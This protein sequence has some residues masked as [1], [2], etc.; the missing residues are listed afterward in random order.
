[1][2]N[3][4]RVAL[5]LLAVAAAGF[6]VARCV[7][8]SIPRLSEV[9]VRESV[10]ATLQRE[11]DTAFVVTGYVDMVVTARST[12]TRVLL[13]DLLDLRLGTTRATVRVPGRVSYGFDVSELRPESIRLAGDTVELR[14]PAPV[15]YSAEPDLSRMEVET[16]TGWA[17]LPETARD[18]ERRAVQHLSAVLR[19]QAAA[20]LRDAVQPRVNTARALERLLTPTLQSLGV[21]DPVFR[22]RIGD[23][24]VVEPGELPRR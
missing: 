18:A 4:V 12:D 7:R 6:L 2:S 21:A 3:R 10:L 8:S 1:M 15:V 17:R 9:Q 20:H 5:V 22:I 16:S 11:A 23:G 19:S 13:P 24:M 14:V